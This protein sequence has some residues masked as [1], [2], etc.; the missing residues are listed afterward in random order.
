MSLFPDVL[1][2]RLRDMPG[3]SHSFLRQ[4]CSPEAGQARAAIERAVYAMDSGLRLGLEE[5]LSS[6]D[7]R[8]FF[9]GFA[10]LV[11]ASALSSGGWQVSSGTCEGRLLRASHPDGG[12]SNVIVLGFIHAQRPEFDQAGVRKLVRAL[13]RVATTLRFSIYVRRW[14]P[15]E[16]DPEPVRRAVELWLRE[17]EEGAWEG[18]Q[19]AYEDDGV[20]LEFTLMGQEVKDGQSPVAMAAGPFVAS[21]VMQAL[22][23]RVV[24]ELDRYR[25][26]SQG[27]QPVLVVAVADQPW[28]LSRGY[29][30]EFL[31]GKPR[32]IS[33]ETHDVRDSSSAVSWE[34]GLSREREPCLFKDSVYQS[35]QGLLLM[36][37]TGRD[38]LEVAGRAYSNPYA[39]KSLD[40]GCCPVPTLYC[41]RTED[42]LPVLRWGTEGRSRFL[43]GEA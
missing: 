11:A 21:R 26:G 40:P 15:P 42:D 30:R 35:V 23:R 38:P 4:L 13:E 8:V 28:Q 32:F 10:E 9:Q 24:R 43:L 39:R 33:S 7:N 16:F 34:A 37:R 29:M 6:L 1:V 2:K 5:R 36:E 22:E 12:E 27:D 3:A 31:M 41:H 25:L 18:T 14:L 19:A 17:C 20:A